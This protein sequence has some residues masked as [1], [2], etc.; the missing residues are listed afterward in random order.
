MPSHDGR[1]QA[2]RRSLGPLPRLGVLLSVVLLAVA[3]PSSVAAAGRGLVVLAQTRYEVQPEAHRV[4]VTIDAVA[5]SY[6]PDTDNAQIYY[7]GVNFAVQAGAANVSASSGGQQIGVAI[8][9]RSD[10]FSIVEVTFGHGVFF[11]QSYAYTVAFDLVDA[12][13]AGTRDLRIGRS[14]AAFPVWAF[15]TQG[16]TGSSVRVDLPK[17]YAPDLQGDEMDA[18]TLADG[19]TRLSAEPADPFA[20]FT[21]LS[22]DR[23]GAFA[24]TDL[25]LDINGVLA[26]MT[27]RSWD[28]DPQWGQRVTQL[29]REGLPALQELIGVPLPALR[30]LT[31]EEAATSRLGEYAGIYD[32]VTGQFR[33]RYD[34]DAF[35][36]LHEAAHIWFNGS[37]FPDRWIGEAWAEFYGVEAGRSIGANG[38]TVELT[39]ALLKARIP[40]NDWGAIGVESLDVEDFAYA[41]SYSLAQ[42]IVKRT[43]LDHMQ[44]V[45]QAAA[46]DEMSYQPS[47][48]TD[49][50]VIVSPFGIEG[51]QRL[52][53]LLEERTGVGYTDLWRNWVVN[54]DQRPML[55]ARQAVRRQYA[56]VVKAA[57]DWELP[58]AI[59]SYIGAWEFGATKSALTKATAVL[60]DREAIMLIA[61][62]LDLTPPDTLREAFEGKGGMSAAATE[63]A[64]EIAAMK[65]L[66]DATR[67]LDDP[68]GLLESIGLL[69]RNVPSELDV[70]RTRFQDG[71]VPG[72]AQAATQAVDALINAADLGRGRVVVG[73]AGVLLLDGI[74]MGVLF[75]QRRHRQRRRS[76]PLS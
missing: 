42:D 28:D 46:D 34:A 35:V 60:E 5:T 53:D 52:L 14:L 47:H 4:H 68:L 73:G 59:R 41:A 21:Y 36:T 13:G 58:T 24:N 39:D 44:L 7:S 8:S 11:H 29:M 23:P 33:V 48:A 75:S 55:A 15:G 57:G 64:V 6:E 65:K 62:E 19:G 26:R 10:D 49:E 56:E 27:I 70:A 40:L 30:R 3:V 76:M 51:W 32:P 66:G 18:S 22:A 12:G 63:A 54:K 50:P 71:D 74:G 17:S 31:V 45:W 16:E 9:R 72:A 61:S 38:I 25:R 20:F 69:G 2:N 67:R 1:N 37:L 43:D